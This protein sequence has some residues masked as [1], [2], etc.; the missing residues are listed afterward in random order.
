MYV[1]MSVCLKYHIPKL[2][3]IIYLYIYIYT[4]MGTFFISKTLGHFL[5]CSLWFLK[6]ILKPIEQNNINLA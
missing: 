2:S 1:F 5:A 3:W 6:F 4:Y